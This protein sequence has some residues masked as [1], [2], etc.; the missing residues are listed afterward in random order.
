M[1]S[2]LS[3]I[4]RHC[5]IDFYFLIL[6]INTL[7]YYNMKN[8]ISVSL[9]IN[10][11][12][13]DD[14][15]DAPIG[16][17]NQNKP[18]CWEDDDD[19]LLCSKCSEQ[20]SMTF[21]KHHCRN[22]GKIYC[23]KCSNYFIKFP[24]STR[25]PLQKNYFD[26][27]YFF[28]SGQ[29]RVCVDCY[30]NIEEITKLNEISKFFNLLPID[31]LD[32]I[33][34]NQVCHTWNKIAG[35][36]FNKFKRLYHKFPNYKFN[37][38]QQMALY[39]NRYNFV[40]H[41]NWIVQLYISFDWG[42]A[43]RETKLDLLGLLDYKFTTVPCRGLSCCKFCRQGLGIEDIFI[44]LSRNIV[45]KL[46]IKKLIN[47]LK[48]LIIKDG[49]YKEFGCYLYAFVNLLRFYKRYTALSVII[50]NF[51]LNIS[52]RN[53]EISNRLF[54][55]LTQ[56]IDNPD[57]GFYFKAFRVKLVSQLDKKDYTLF[58]NGY[59][60]TQNLIRIVNSDPINAVINLQRFLKDFS[61]NT[62]EFTIPI[63]MS[64]KFSAVDYTQL[65]DVDSKTK[66]IILPCI[67]EGDKIY[68]IML[69]NEDIRKEAIIM[70][71][72]KLINF[73]LLE[74]DGLDLNIITYNILPISCTHGYIEFV[75]DSKTLYHIKE[76]L[77]FSIQNWII[78]NNKDVNIDL[79]RDNICKSCAAYCVITYLL[80]IGDR[81]LDNIM[82]TTQGKLFHI[83]FGYILGTD[84]KLI[85]PEIRLTPEII[86]AMGGI[87][88][89]YYTHFKQYVNTAFECIKRH[90]RTF[91]LL[92]LDLTKIYPRPPNISEEYI[93]NYIVNRFMPTG[94]GSGW[95]VKQIEAKIDYHS[96]RNS[97]AETIIDYFHKKNK[98]TRSNSSDSKN[99]INRALDYS[100]KTKD[101]VMKGLYNWF[102]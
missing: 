11:E 97:Y 102:K 78:E 6:K 37:K 22:C 83:D 13:R 39:I 75:P 41:S 76:D 44:I 71:V 7:V 12:I 46:L 2:E 65:R 25:V 15:E 40:A 31:L 55:L 43:T 26:Y 28:E 95:A 79:I 93:Y 70:N 8:E 56:S 30:S 90:S 99:S 53:I 29:N 42:N 36:Y 4:N 48:K 17:L 35:I 19:V 92:L 20:F 101:S 81:H 57:S 64:R 62:P 80:G 59:D 27:N 50:Q 66:P 91:Y 100:L 52:S 3:T 21:R 61:N 1:W 16:I 14:L 10:D 77:N 34:I 87:H 67:Y 23:F 74:E 18:H 47:I 82:I 51:L 98:L 88:S 54:W 63:N 49:R 9:L 24:K 85:S 84:P 58:Q 86:D 94:R 38:N 60:F 73:F 33:K 45:D 72:I 69:K 5:I 89:K 96:V 32:Y 68:N